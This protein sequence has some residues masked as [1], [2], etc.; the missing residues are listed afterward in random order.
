MAKQTKK[1]TVQNGGNSKQEKQEAKPEV[2]QETKQEAKQEV[3]Q[4]AKPEAPQTGGK[5]EP[6]RKKAIAHAK[7]LAKQAKQAGGS[8]APAENETKDRYFKCEY[9]GKTFGRYSG[10]K[11]KQ[12]ANKAL[13]SI[14]KAEGGN[15]KCLGRKFKFQII[16][17]TRGRKR[18][19]SLYEGLREKLDEPMKIKIK[20][21]DG[22]PKE[23]VYKYA[24]T[25]HK[26]T[27]N[28]EQTGG[29]KAKT[30][31]KKPVKK[32]QKKPAKKVAGKN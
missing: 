18:K 19:T 23:I 9:G 3:K 10:S 26:V 29:K 22:V 11:P 2:K 14:V 27:E 5:K 17:C 20:G 1:N 15:E 28:T 32:A 31:K 13:T 21:S 25:L 6:R 24:N 8:A 30:Q 4:E 16:E 12:A 7:A